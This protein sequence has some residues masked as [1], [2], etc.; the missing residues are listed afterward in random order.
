MN[1]L[2]FVSQ[3][4]I[5]FTFER[6]I[7]KVAVFD[8]DLQ[9]RPFFIGKGKGEG[10]GEL[11]GITDMDVHHDRIYLFSGTR[12]VVWSIADTL[13]LDKQMAVEA[14]RGEAL[15]E[16]RI[17][18][19][20]P[21]SSDYLFNILDLEGKIIRGF[22]RTNLGKVTPLRYSG[23]LAFDGKYLYYAG[24]SES[25]LKKYTLEGRQLFSVATI[26]NL[27]S[28]GNYVQFEAGGE[29]MAMGYSPW[30]LF[31]TATIEVYDAYLLAVP[32]HDENRKPLSYLDI[33]ATGDGRYV[34]TYD[35]A[36]MPLAL[37]VDADGIY[38][39]EREGD[40]VY[41]KRYPNVLTTLADN[42]PDTP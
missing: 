3:V 4:R 29:S 39:L 1:L 24:E 7:G 30:V 16:H 26:D 2:N 5:F 25:F 9:A 18:I 34:A 27:P 12:L 37:A 19:L 17:L 33:Y 21:T 6:N 36:R 13:V 41:L 8:R 32:I 20:S 42:R 40:D 31:S 35:L 28:E 11:T 14:Y 22:V 10:P 15:D 23:D 38:T